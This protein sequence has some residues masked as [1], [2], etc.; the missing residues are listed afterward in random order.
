MDRLRNS[1][2]GYGIDQHGILTPTGEE[3]LEGIGKRINEM[4]PSLFKHPKPEQFMV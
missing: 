1:S 2:I 3:Q 4:F